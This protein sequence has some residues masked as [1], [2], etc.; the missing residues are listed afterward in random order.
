MLNR[1]IILTLGEIKKTFQQI[2]YPKNGKITEMEIT[3]YL[4]NDLII[5]VH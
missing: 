1:N 2:F 3:P 5:K 4:R